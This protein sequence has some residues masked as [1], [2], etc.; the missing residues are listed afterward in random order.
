MKSPIQIADYI[1]RARWFDDFLDGLKREHPGGWQATADFL[2]GLYEE[3]TIRDAFTWRD[4]KQGY[5]FW[6]RIDDDF[7][8][9]LKS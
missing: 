2:S 6:K 7:Q 1:R 4:S 5:D 9:W 8:E 3:E